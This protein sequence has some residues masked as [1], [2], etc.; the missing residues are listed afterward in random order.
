MS[1]NEYQHFD[2]DEVKT[3]SCDIDVGTNAILP[4]QWCGNYH[5]EVC[6]KVKKIE[7]HRNGTIKSVEFFE[8][9]TVQYLSNDDGEPIEHN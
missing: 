7:Y 1:N 9:M 5:T 8:K 3:T 4:C 2:Y 6:S